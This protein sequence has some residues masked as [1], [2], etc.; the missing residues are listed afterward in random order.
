MALAPALI[1]LGLFL[2]AMLT[3]DEYVR[4][5]DLS[6]GSGAL[7]TAGALALMWLLAGAINWQISEAARAQSR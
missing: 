5:A 3:Q 4:L 1:A 6:A 2:V 7:A